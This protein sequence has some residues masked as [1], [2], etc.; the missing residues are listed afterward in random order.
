MADFQH[1][2]VQASDGVTVVQ[3]LT[4]KLSDSLTVSEF[5]DELLG[6]LESEQPKNVVVSFNGVL[7][8]STAVI[9][10]LLRAKKRL[11]T[12]DGGL[13]LCGMTDVIRDAYRLLHLD[14]TVFDIDETLEESL[15]GFR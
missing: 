7:H 3:I 6:M 2:S 15:A 4:P 12:I 10:G 9:N 11:L 13:R 5:Q 8:C 14:G 1:F